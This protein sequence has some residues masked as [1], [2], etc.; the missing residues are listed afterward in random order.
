MYPCVLSCRLQS[1]YAY[2]CFECLCF[3]CR[4]AALALAKAGFQVFAGVRNAVDGESTSSLH[5]NIHYIILDVTDSSSI[6]AALRRVQQFTADLGLP[7]VAVVAN[8]GIVKEAP[9]EFLPMSDIR[10]VMEVNYFGAL[11]LV[12]AFIPLTRQH[13]GRVVF[14]SSFAGKIS[15]PELGAYCASKAAINAVAEVLRVEMAAHNVSVSIIIPGTVSTAVYKKREEYLKPLLAAL[16]AIRQLYPA[17][18]WAATLQTSSAWAVTTQFTDAVILHSVASSTPQCEYFVGRAGS[19][20]SAAI[21]YS[22]IA[23]LPLRLS[24]WIK[25][26]AYH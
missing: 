26:K 21:T 15:C 13:Q 4:S 7:F 5:A 20:A 6:R 19:P 17:S 2:T 18:H 9:L 3:R 1:L 11:A 23:L 14:I 8:A 25:A 16:P 10:D 12:Q 24:D 22:I